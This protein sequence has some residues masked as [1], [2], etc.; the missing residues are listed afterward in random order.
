MKNRN[1]KLNYIKNLIREE[2]KSVL[3]GKKRFLYEMEDSPKPELVVMPPSDRG[4]DI[5]INNVTKAYNLLI[6]QGFNSQFLRIN[7]ERV[8]ASAILQKGKGTNDYIKLV[9]T[10]KDKNFKFAAKDFKIDS[11]GEN[12]ILNFIHPDA[13]SFWGELEIFIPTFIKVKID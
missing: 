9:L 7:P 2:V 12:I 8:L 5:Y 4:T 11:K 6:L 1:D 13:V 3:G 10:S